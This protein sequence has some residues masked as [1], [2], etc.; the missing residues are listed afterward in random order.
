MRKLGSH[1][2]SICDPK[3]A[4]LHRLDD[5]PGTKDCLERGVSAGFQVLVAVS[6]L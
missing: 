5:L 6:G 2:A 1:G 4:K 3:R